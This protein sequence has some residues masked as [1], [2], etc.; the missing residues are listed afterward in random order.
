MANTDKGLDYLLELNGEIL[1]Q[2]H[3]CWIKIE[4]RRVA[5]VDD[6]FPHGIKYSL[7][8]HDRSGIR[9]LGFDNAHAIS[10]RKK[11]RYKARTVV[12]DHKHIDPK[13]KGI[14]YVFESADQLLSDFFEAVDRALK[15]MT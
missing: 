1:A 11:G 5:K 2:E 8:L 3:G 6:R 12:Y 10:T 15:E 14:P 9:L 7:T 4:A 13:D